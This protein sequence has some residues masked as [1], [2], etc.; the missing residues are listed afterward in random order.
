MMR[1]L[2]VTV[3]LLAFVA[4][5]VVACDKPTG[6]EPAVDEPA[7]ADESAQAAP[8]AESD[9]DAKA[10]VDEL[11]GVD[12]LDERRLEA[13]HQAREAKVEQ[14]VPALREL[15]DSDNPDIIVASAAALEGLEV[16]EAGGD[17][18]EA[19]S[20]LSRDQQFEHLRQL[21]FVVGDVGGPEARIYLETVADGHQVPGIRQT[22]AQVLED[23]KP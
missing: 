18:V 20:Q 5:G 2:S 8:D 4:G 1:Y 19:A 11:T 17:I 21:L 3:F 16:E 9:V 13:I 6:D 12:V 7:A 23:T 14:A 10:L 22:A 15:L